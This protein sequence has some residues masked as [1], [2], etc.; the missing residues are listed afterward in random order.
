MLKIKSKIINEQLKELPIIR[1]NELLKILIVRLLYRVE[2][3][4][5]K[6]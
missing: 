1:M 6:I 5:A 3:K 2:Q 4:Y